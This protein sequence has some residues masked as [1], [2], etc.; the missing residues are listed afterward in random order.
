[1]S[2]TGVFLPTTNPRKY[3]LSGRRV[4]NR[5]YVRK[6]ILSGYFHGLRTKAYEWACVLNPQTRPANQREG[7]RQS[8]PA[9]LEE[10]SGAR[11]LLPRE[12][13]HRPQGTVVKLHEP[14]RETASVT[15]RS[16]PARLP[17][18]GHGAH[19]A[20]KG[21]HDTAECTAEPVLSFT[22]QANFHS[23]QKEGD[24]TSSRDFPRLAP[25]EPMALRGPALGSVSSRRGHRCGECRGAYAARVPASR[26]P[27]DAPAGSASG[28][29]KTP[30]FAA[31]P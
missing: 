7:D 2:C 10:R 1:M 15:A 28:L 12:V 4:V 20:V 22:F 6:H 19:A 27:E 31:V 9:L 25:E 3:Q 13:R 16:A 26:G 5:L 21:Q 18:L 14:S 30:G 23:A 11:G 17:A 29:P 24:L 8:V